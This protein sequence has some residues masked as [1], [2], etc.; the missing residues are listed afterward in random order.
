MAGE[1]TDKYFGPEQEQAVV[2]FAEYCH[3]NG[4]S[5]LISLSGGEP[6]LNLDDVLNLANMCRRLRLQLSMTT[7]GTLVT[8]ETAASLRER[9]PDHITVSIDSADHEIHDYIRGRSGTLEKAANALRL[10]SIRPRDRLK[11]RPMIVNAQSIL[12]KRT[13]PGLY[14]TIELARSCGAQSFFFQPLMPTF[15]RHGDSDPFYEQERF[16]TDE[17]RKQAFDTVTNTLIWASKNFPHFVGHTNQDIQAL[18]AYLMGIKP[19]VPVCN[20]HEK[21]VIL[22]KTGEVE[23]CFHMKEKITDGQPLPGNLF[24]DNL[25][26]IMT[27]EFA[28]NTVEKMSKCQESCGLLGC[29]RRTLID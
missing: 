12:M 19:D 20:S 4:R 18:F 5:G 29:H 11:Y 26:S 7:N 6:L 27:S 10:L 17:E 13:V 24:T 25:Q 16:S 14:K 2:K 28:A 15:D 22:S 8:E 21:N 9:G 1:T 3:A 23:L